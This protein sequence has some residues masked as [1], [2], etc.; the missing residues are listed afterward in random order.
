LLNTAA[1]AASLKKDI[2][3]DIDRLKNES[4]SFE[5]NISALKSEFSR[6]LNAPGKD[7]QRLKDKYTLSPQGMA[8]MSQL[9]LGT[10][11][12]E[13]WEKAYVWYQ[14]VKP[15]LRPPNTKASE[16]EMAA[17]VRGKGIN[18]R[19]PEKTPLPDFLIR[20][21]RAN[22]VL[23]LGELTAVIENVSAEQHL[24]GEPATFKFLGRQLSGMKS[25]DAIGEMNHL[26]PDYPKYKLDMNI[27]ALELKDF[28]LSTAQALPLTIQASRTDLDFNF[29][30]TGTD[31]IAQLNAGFRA[32]K[33]TAGTA[34]GSSGLAGA[35]A[36]AISGVDAFDVKARMSGPVDEYTFAVQ[37][38]LDTILK[39][40]VGDLL[41]KETAKLTAALEKEVM[42]RVS[43]PM[44]E[45]D[46]QLKGFKP[47]GDELGKRLD[48]GSDLLKTD[49]FKRVKLP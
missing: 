7:I 25:L 28:A 11:F 26:Q 49:V 45:A 12:C 33:M 47:I 6:V 35:F 17:P 32:V 4:K 40:A 21:A 44:A 27:K 30:L 34:A 14:R 18:V 41:R 9:L 42:A 1:D 13:W 46:Q 10:R 37:S 29:S 20:L 2:E 48:L 36:A 24:V 43:G 39:N 19:F 31:V 3:R 22:I 23:G 5:K 16:A 38:D 8:N 15:Y